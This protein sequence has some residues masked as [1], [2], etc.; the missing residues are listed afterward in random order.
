MEYKQ[1]G[2]ILNTV[3]DDVIGETEQ[4]VAEDL[5]NIVEVGHTITSSSQ[6]GNQFENYVKKLIDRVGKVI[7][8]QNDLNLMHLPIFKDSW[9]FGSIAEK[10]RVEAPPTKEDQTFEL[11]DIASYDPSDIFTPVLPEVSAKF[12]NNSTTFAI[13]ITIPKRQLKSAFTSASEMSRFI[14]LIENSIQQKL[15]IDLLSLEYR[16]EA[17]L[18]AEK[19]LSGNNHSLVNLLY[20]WLRDVPG[21]AAAYGNYTKPED[22][23]TDPFFLRY[24]NMRIGMYRDFIKKPSVLYADGGY[25]NTTSDKQ[26]TLLLLTDFDKALDTWLYSMNRHN[27]FVELDGY[28]SVPYWMSGGETDEYSKRST[29]HAIPASQGHQTATPDTRIVVKMSNILGVLHDERASAITCEHKD[30]ESINVPNNR[31]INYWYFADANYINDTDENVVVFYLSEYYA[32]GSFEDEAAFIAATGS[33]D[34]ATDGSKYY[35]F[36]GG[37]TQY[38]AYTG[39]ETFPADTPLYANIANM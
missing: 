36:V 37:D 2:Q 8:R 21:A 32:I 25:I 24:A 14:S 19:F 28:T 29:I 31:T 5:S 27:D 9:E 10:I 3:F 17:N 22:V 7:F 15:A 12:F 6:W 1:I 16:T 18:I 23:L 38:S 13:K 30:V 26:Q 35:Q 34:W 20:E 11:W 33:T 4:T 39:S